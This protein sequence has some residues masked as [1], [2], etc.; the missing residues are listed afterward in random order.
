MR[1]VVVEEGICLVCARWNLDSA[2]V[3]AAAGDNVNTSLVQ[4]LRRYILRGHLSVC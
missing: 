1:A 4:A 2:A 3:A